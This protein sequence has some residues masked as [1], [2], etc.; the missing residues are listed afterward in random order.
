MAT[1]SVSLRDTYV[2]LVGAEDMRDV[3]EA[4][5]L[6]ADLT[7]EEAALL[8]ERR[9][10]RDVPFRVEHAR[11]DAAVGP[12]GRRDQSRAGH[13]QRAEAIPVALL[14]RRAADHI[15]KRRE[16]RI[17]ALHIRRIGFHSRFRGFALLFIGVAPCRVLVA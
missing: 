15:V 13:E 2:S 12:L 9:G 4:L 5:D 11:F 14:A 3:A 10:S 16:N 6:A 1:S 7:L 8:K 17:H